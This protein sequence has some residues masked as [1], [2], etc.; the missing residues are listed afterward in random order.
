MP[1]HPRRTIHELTLTTGTSYPNPFVDV[2]VRVTFTA[3]SG[4]KQTIE[5]FHDGSDIWKVRFNPGETG[6]WSWQSTSVPPDPDF[7]RS[8]G[9]TVSE[10]P[11]KGF[12]KSTPG[13]AWGFSFENGDPVFIFGDT[14]YH[15][16]GVAHNSEEGATAVER[17]L[18]RRAEQGFNLLR[19]RVPVSEFHPVDG[20]NVWQTRSLWP[21]R[22]SPQAPRFDQFNLDY[23]RTVDNVV[24]ACERLGIGIE[25]IVEAWGFEFPFN[26]RN[27]FTAAWED[28]WIRYLVA[29][30]DAFNALW[31]WQ[32]QNEY[33]YYPN[34]DWNY[35]RSGVADRW[36]I[37]IAHRIRELA[38]HGHPIAIHN[39][40]Q[41][42]P[43]AD[44]FRSD[45]AAIDTVMYQ[46]WGTT[47]EHDG[48]LAAGIETRLDEALGTWPGSKVLAEWGYEFNPD[49]PPMMLGHRWCDADHTRRGGWRGAMRGMGIIHGFEN[50]WGP[51][52]ELDDDLPGL[53]HLLHLHRFFTEIVPFA[54]LRPDQTLVKE[55]AVP[56]GQAPLTMANE[57]RNL[58]VIYLPVGGDVRIVDRQVPATAQWFDPRSGVLGVEQPAPGP[59][60]TPPEPPVGERPDDW[61]LILRRQA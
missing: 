46:T 47:G 37:Q 39:G 55:E 13:T 21:W 58:V 20:Y 34:G 53:E 15:L 2:T 32:L 6:E 19:I 44:R 57:E 56:P 60:F 41:L 27:V 38:P 1:N 18:A 16:F 10:T 14:T 25:M 22:G 17:F 36:A 45:P 40:P 52:A 35:D 59:V 9:L 23:F 4:R 61:V 5:A 51:F 48:W 54:Q 7:E 33:E 8:G 26:N 42:P 43:L 11:A 12:L 49:L 28:L 24:H 50:S 29:R 31:F 30:Y 3:P